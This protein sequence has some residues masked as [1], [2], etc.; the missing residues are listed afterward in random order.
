MLCQGRA[1]LGNSRYKIKKDAFLFFGKENLP[2]EYLHQQLFPNFSLQAVC[3]CFP[4]FL[5]T[6]GELPQMGILSTFPTLA[7]QNPP[8]PPANHPCRYTD[9]AHFSFSIAIS[10]A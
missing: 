6:A 7:D 2:G 5:L 10:R 3:G 9:H 1:F 8:I 4:C